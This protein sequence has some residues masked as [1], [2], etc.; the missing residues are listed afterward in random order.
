MIERVLILKQS[1]NCLTQKER[2]ESKN[3][4]SN[5]WGKYEEIKQFLQP[6]YESTVLIS[7]SSYQTL[8]IVLPIFDK[9]LSHLKEYKSEEIIK[10]CALNIEEK[11]LKYKTE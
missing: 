7:G 2:F 1:L 9:L 4:D 8:I 6:C 11:L 10:K 3:I 5:L